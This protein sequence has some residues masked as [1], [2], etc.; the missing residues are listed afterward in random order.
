MIRVNDFGIDDSKDIKDNGT[1]SVLVDYLYKTIDISFFKYE[2]LQ[3]EHEMQQLIKQKYYVSAN[4]SGSS[5]FYIFAKIKNIY[6]SYLIDRK[7]LSYNIQNV[8]VNNVNVINTKVKLDPSIYLG[9]IFDGIFI[10]TKHSNIFVITD[11]YMF[12]GQLMTTVPMQT[13]IHTI[14]TYLKSNYSENDKDNTIVITINKL[15]DLKNIEHLVDNVI[16]CIKNFIVKGICFY[17]DISGTKIIY[18]FSKGKTIGKPDECNTMG[19]CNTTRRMSD[20][21]SNGN[22]S[23]NVISN[24]V[25][26]NKHTTYC[27]P[28][29]YNI[30]NA[31]NS[32][33]PV[34]LPV[35][36]STTSSTTSS[37]D[38][39]L[40]PKKDNIDYVFQMRKTNMIDVYTLHVVEI[41]NSRLKNIKIGIAY[42]PDMS[43]SKWCRNIVAQ[44]QGNPL[45]V[46]CRFH[47]QKN[48]WEPFA[49]ST[50]SR[51]SYI[52]DFNVGQ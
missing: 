39:H 10:H 4:F 17:P 45:L 19:N 51:P 40:L 49:T 22:T 50:A 52:T 42:I 15:F 38:S 43:S 13:K 11:V 21:H 14:F 12:K 44:N 24:N 6:Y 8:N 32:T 25:I 3:Y 16:P 36:S 23:N 41:E 29:P 5:C 9:T 48:K 28:K 27:S 2:I 47:P 35:T 31:I 34:A 7:T 30:N 37:F 20:E 26:S 33:P 46:K 1:K 18:L